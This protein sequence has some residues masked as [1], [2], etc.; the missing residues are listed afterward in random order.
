MLANNNAFTVSNVEFIG[1]FIELS[2]ESLSIVRNN[3]GGGPLQYVVQ[4]YANYTSNATL[5]T[6]ATTVSLPVPAK[7]AS[8]RSLF[9]IMRNKS[10]GDVLHFS[11]SST[12]FNI[13]DWRIRIGSQLIPY[14]SPSTMVEHFAELIKAIGS[15]SDVNHEP[16]INWYSYATNAQLVA[17]TETSQLLNQTTKS[18]CFALGFD[19]ETYGGADKEKLFSGMNTLNSDIFWNIAFGA[20]G[21]NTN[22]RFDFY[23]LYDNLLV[24]ENGVCYSKR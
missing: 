15:M 4:T 20:Q 9:C 1:S 24:F 21:A 16:S 6:G 7:F 3:L 11:Q 17:N 5:G 18:D 14:K 23:S 8:L 2:D 10:D 13:V 19:L 12:H 22:V